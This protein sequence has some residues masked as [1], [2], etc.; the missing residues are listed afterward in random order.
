MTYIFIKV[1]VFLSILLIVIW[2]IFVFC[3]RGIGII[4]RSKCIVKKIDDKLLSSRFKL[5]IVEKRN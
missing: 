1:L 4:I 5:T 2:L 3:E